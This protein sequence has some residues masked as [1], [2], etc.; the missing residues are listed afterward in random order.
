MW[1]DTFSEDGKEDKQA[2]AK[3]TGAYGIVM[4]TSHHEPLYRAGKEWARYYKKDLDYT[5]A[6]A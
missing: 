1:V 3:L 4:G 5:S 2:N 6:E